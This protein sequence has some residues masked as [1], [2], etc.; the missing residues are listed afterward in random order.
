MAADDDAEDATTT[1]SADSREPG[2]IDPDDGAAQA[3]V[4]ADTRVGDDNSAYHPTQP[5]AWHCPP[6]YPYPQYPH[7]QKS[8]PRSDNRI[9]ITLAVAVLGAALAVV[10]FE[11]RGMT[12]GLVLLVVGCLAVLWTVGRH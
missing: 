8:P 4:S 7:P 1:H 2:W 10:G 6:T 11:T 5:T 9:R 12:T 3:K